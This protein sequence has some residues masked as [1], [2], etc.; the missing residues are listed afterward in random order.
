MKF[1][2]GELNSRTFVG[3]IIDDDK[4]LDLQKAEKKLFELETIPG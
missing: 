3:L 4:I 1:A 2:T